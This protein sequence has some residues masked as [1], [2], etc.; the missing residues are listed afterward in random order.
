[1]SKQ[2]STETGKRKK[3]KNSKSQYD[4]K[5]LTDKQTTSTEKQTDDKLEFAKSIKSKAVERVVAK[6]ASYFEFRLHRS[7]KVSSCL[8]KDP[9]L[10]EEEVKG[11]LI[12]VKNS[13][14]PR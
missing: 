12:T 4:G 5:D 11:K 1:M 2:S 8:L 14:K 10:K 7:R 6:A 13:V 9:S 3:T